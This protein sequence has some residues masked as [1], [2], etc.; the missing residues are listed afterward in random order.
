MCVPGATRSLGSKPHCEKRFNHFRFRMVK[1]G[2]GNR[3]SCEELNSGF[4]APRARVV[5]ALTQ[6]LYC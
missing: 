3:W 1:R 2:G 4:E 5:A 6:C